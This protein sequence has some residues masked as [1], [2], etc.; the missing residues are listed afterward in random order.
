[1]LRLEESFFPKW[2][3]KLHSFSHDGENNKIEDNPRH[4]HKDK[5]GIPISIKFQESK[6]FL[7][8]RHASKHQSESKDSANEKVH[9]RPEKS[10]EV[11]VSW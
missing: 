6:Y 8:F 4:K 2:N 11:N 9:D 7:S 3:K 5:G 1:M 10:V